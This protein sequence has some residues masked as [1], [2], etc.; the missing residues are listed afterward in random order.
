[1]LEIAVVVVVTAPNA[2]ALN[3]LPAPKR[4]SCR[5][6]RTGHDVLK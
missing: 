3:P 6:I 5:V 4:S 2:K 1:M